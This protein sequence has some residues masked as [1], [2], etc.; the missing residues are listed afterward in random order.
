MFSPE[1]RLQ[2]LG[3]APVDGLWG[4]DAVLLDIL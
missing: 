3:L 4:S 2:S 1:P